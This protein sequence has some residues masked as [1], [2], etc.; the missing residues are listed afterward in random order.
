MCN[1]VL[2]IL[3]MGKNFVKVF[4]GNVLVLLSMC[5]VCD[6]VVII[7]C[8]KVVFINLFFDVN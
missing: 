3:L 5:F 4:F 7:V 2:W 8:F 1:L 6:W